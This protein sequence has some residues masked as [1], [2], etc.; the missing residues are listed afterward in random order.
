[1]AL[2]RWLVRCYKCQ[3][4]ENFFMSYVAADVLNT[5]IPVLYKNVTLAFWHGLNRGEAWR[6]SG[7]CE[8]DRTVNVGFLLDWYCCVSWKFSDDPATHEDTQSVRRYHQISELPLSS[9]YRLMGGSV[10][11]NRS[12]ILSPHA[13]WF[14]EP[15]FSSHLFSILFFGLGSWRV[16]VKLLNAYLEVKR[17]KPTFLRICCLRLDTL[18][19]V[20]FVGNCHRRPDISKWNILIL[21]FLEIMVIHLLLLFRGDKLVVYLHWWTAYN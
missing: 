14:C 13:C 10:M 15:K 16:K 1:M 9:V 20:C 17:L 18:F 12:L 6:R 5:F 4:I 3:L 19:S 8:L 2:I 7:T 21:I 11:L